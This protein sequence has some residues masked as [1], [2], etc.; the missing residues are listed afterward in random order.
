MPATTARL[1][2]AGATMALAGALLPAP[3]ALAASKPAPF[4]F[5]HT[6]L[7]DQGA[8]GEP[9]L[10][11]SRDGHIVACVPGGSGTYDWYSSNDGRTFGTSKTESTNG[12][13][14]CELDFVPKPGSKED[15]L[16]NA[17]L[18]ITDSAIHYSNDYGKTFTA[19]DPAGTEQ[20]RQ[21][22]A[23]SPD[24][25]TAY[26]V[27]HDFAAEAELYAQS[28]DGGITWP[29]ASGQMPVNNVGQAA[30]PG[31]AQTPA[32]SKPASL[33]DQGVNTFS[34]PMVVSPDGK[35]LYVLYSISNLQT[36][37]TSPTPPF[38]GTKGIVVAHKGAKDSVFSNN[39]A[40]VDS[41]KTLNGAIFPWGFVDNDGNVYVV[42]NSDK[43]SPGNFHAYY[44]FSTDKAATWSK[45]VKL[46]DRPLDKGAQIYSTGAGGAPGVIDVAWYGT[47]GKN[48]DD[49]KAVWNVYFAQVRNAT[50]K[51]PQITRA[52][53]SANPIHKGNVCLNGLLCIAGGDRSLLDFFELAIG[54]DGLAQLAYA[55]NDGYTKGAKGANGAKDSGGRVTWAKQTTGSPAFTPRPLVRPVKGP[56]KPT[57]TAP[58]ASGPATSAVG[59]GS[60]GGGSSGT[61][62]SSGG[63]AG[64]GRGLAATGLASAYPGAAVLLLL[65]AAVAVRRRRTV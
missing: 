51:T 9:S 45:P 46:D 2:A 24:G 58:S 15:R 61:G 44:V 53:V 13:G 56:G 7:A 32:K 59:S 25:K 36:N 62:G 18:E 8:Y 6:V 14:D 39:Y 57:A 37:L 55:D 33:V 20:D 5:R 35:D 50:G 52:T 63:G 60:S 31:V 48:A 64:S 26:L 17:D 10:A 4:A 28:N 11:I 41:D 40:V 21:W 19:T 49:N 1:A 65:A 29:K 3:S 16:L 54:P 34:G 47:D 43:G 23:H 42:Y 22:F 30:A 27:Y 12:G 38:G